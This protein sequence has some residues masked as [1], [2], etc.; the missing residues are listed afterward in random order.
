MRGRPPKLTRE[1]AMA[2]RKTYAAQ[3]AGM[4]TLAARYGVSTSL[5]SRIIKGQYASVSDQPDI[6]RLGLR[7][8]PGRFAVMERWNG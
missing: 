4:T 1:Q 7:S 6:A 8:I 3:L 5:I 2:I